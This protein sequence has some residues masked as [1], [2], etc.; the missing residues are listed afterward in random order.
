[1]ACW[2][3]PTRAP[4]GAAGVPAQHGS[5]L[6]SSWASQGKGNYRLFMVRSREAPII[7]SAASHVACRSVSLAV[8]RGA[9]GGR[10]GS[11][12]AWLPWCHGAT[13]EGK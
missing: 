13:L 12:G 6:S 8:C 1:M 2:L 5:R 4:H 9:K 10:W 11:V 3:F 7:T